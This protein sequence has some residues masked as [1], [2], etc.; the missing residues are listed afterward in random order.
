MKKIIQLAKKLRDEDLKKLGW[1]SVAVWGY[2]RDRAERMLKKV[3]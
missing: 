3:C 2:Y 1:R